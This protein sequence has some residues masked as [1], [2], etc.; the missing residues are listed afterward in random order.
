MYTANLEILN[1]EVL[2]L[3]ILNL[4]VFIRDFK[5][6]D[7]R[8]QDFKISAKRDSGF[9]NSRLPK[10]REIVTTGLPGLMGTVLDDRPKNQN[11]TSL[12]NRNSKKVRSVVFMYMVMSDANIAP[13]V[14]VRILKSVMPQSGRP[15]HGNAA[16]SGERGQPL[17]WPLVTVA[18]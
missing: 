10:S 18:V 2:N 8:I 13:N 7:F 6:Q 3:G 9:Q 17:S 15:S 16:A 11:A 1:L 14:V 12:R 5:I 4:E